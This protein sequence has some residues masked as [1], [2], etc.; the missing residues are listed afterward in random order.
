MDSLESEAAS[1]VFFELVLG[2]DTPRQIADSLRE[3]PPSVIEQLHQLQKAGFVR[4]GRKEGKFQHYE[5][6]WD[7]FMKECLDW[8]PHLTNAIVIASTERDE[9][10]YAK[11][12]KLKK[13]LRKNKY[14]QTLFMNYFRRV[15][16]MRQRVDVYL[17]DTNFDTISA[18]IGVFEESLIRLFPSLKKEGKGAAK[19]LSLIETWVNAVSRSLLFRQGPVEESFK[20]IEKTS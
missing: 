15:A 8:A 16:E 3:T 17:I 5:I 13:D 10:E 12:E 7:R 11:L 19:F 2:V 1:S 18:A 14:F 6:N 9:R 4:L 20:E